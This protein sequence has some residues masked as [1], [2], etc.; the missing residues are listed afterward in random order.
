MWGDSNSVTD[1]SFF[2][3][4][5]DSSLCNNKINVITVNPMRQWSEVSMESY[6]QQIDH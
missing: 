1:Q 6:E 2:P 3:T 4:A 5:L